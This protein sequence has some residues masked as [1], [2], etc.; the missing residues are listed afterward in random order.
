MNQDS[1]DLLEMFAQHQVRFLV[2]GAHALGFHG[3]PRYTGDLDL[4]IDCRDDNADRVWLA[5]QD[6]WGAAQIGNLSRDDFSKED[7][8]VQFGFPPNRIDLITGISGLDF[9]SAWQR[10]VRCQ[11]GTLDLPVL[12]LQDLR[13]N[14][15]ACGRKKDLADLE[16]IDRLLERRKGLGL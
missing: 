13:T 11:Q 5:L 9:D 6:F 7:F 2:V 10:Q 4:W 16:T 3:C 15:A 12:G 1:V 8:V 14:K